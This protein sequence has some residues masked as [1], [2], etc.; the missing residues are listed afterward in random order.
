[1]KITNVVYSAHVGCPMD[2]T[3]LCGLLWNTRYDPKTFPGLIWQHR[4]I[5]G[6]CLV[7]A[8]G[9]GNCKGKAA[10]FQEGHQRLRRYARK[11]QKGEIGG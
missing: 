8:K 4:L 9:V 2:L 6:N 1:M 3:T 5:G 10:S 11:L 7:F